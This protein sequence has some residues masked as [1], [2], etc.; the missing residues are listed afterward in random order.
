MQIALLL[1]GGIVAAFLAPLVFRGAWRGFL[2]G[3]HGEDDPRKNAATAPTAMDW[4]G[5]SA[6]RSDDSSIIAGSGND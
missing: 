5:S 4:L 3:F 6:R 1:L 2:A